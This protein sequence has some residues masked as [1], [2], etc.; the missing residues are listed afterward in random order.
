MIKD[1]WKM[2][3]MPSSAHALY[4]AYRLKH[5]SPAAQRRQLDRK[6]RDFV[7]NLLR[8]G[9]D[10]EAL[11]GEKKLTA[12]K[13]ASTKSKVV[14]FLRTTIPDPDEIDRADSWLKIVKPRA[15][16]D[17]PSGRRTKRS[18]DPKREQRLA[19]M[20]KLRKEIASDRDI[21]RDDDEDD[22]TV[23]DDDKPKKR[24]SKEVIYKTPE[25]EEAA[26]KSG[27]WGKRKR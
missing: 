12:A 1:D 17:V 25:E 22:T 18:S 19:D 27:E 5:S 6:F 3:L 8:T 13:R 24:K 4:L 21:D 20:K 9:F 14:E 11:L 2:K 26:L 16:S 7:G 10:D 15:E 23:I